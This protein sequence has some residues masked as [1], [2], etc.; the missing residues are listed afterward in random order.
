MAVSYEWSIESVDIYDDIQDSDFSEKLSSFS[1]SDLDHDPE[2]PEYHKALVLVRNVGN[3]D[4]GLQDREWAYVINKQ[5][6]K[7][8]DRG[9]DVP[10]RFHKELE[11][12]LK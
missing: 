12:W 7:V 11:N 4:D 9:A 5:L 1:K 6:P 3:E 8:F 10:K 2:N